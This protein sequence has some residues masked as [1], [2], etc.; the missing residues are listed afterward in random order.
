MKYRNNDFNQRLIETSNFRVI[1]IS[2]YFWW[3]DI[4]Y[5]DDVFRWD[6]GKHVPKNDWWFTKFLN[7]SGKVFKL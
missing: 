3:L 5:I 4:I 2:R 1:T 6:N 7:Y